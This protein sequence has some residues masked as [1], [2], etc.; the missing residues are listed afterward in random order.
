MHRTHLL[1]L[2]LLLGLPACE[3]AGLAVASAE[4]ASVAV[5][6]RGM[7]DI[8]VSAVTGKDCSIVRLDK[9]Q[10]YCAPR[11]HLPSA[12][13]FCTQTLGTVQCWANP[14]VFGVEPHEL[15]DTPATTADQARNI[16]ARWPKSLNLGD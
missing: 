5:L 9:G 16:A 11:E 8:G 15:A 2:L 14:E 3:P 6:G 4:G 1:L 13:P 12:P 10:T 7:V